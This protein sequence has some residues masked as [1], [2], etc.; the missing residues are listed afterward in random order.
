MNVE[1][2][3]LILCSTFKLSFIS[4]FQRGEFINSASLSLSISIPGDKTFIR[5][6]F[7]YF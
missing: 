7:M 5:K 4:D 6:N 1:L 3:T 2:L